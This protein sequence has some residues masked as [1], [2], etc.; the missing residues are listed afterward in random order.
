[1]AVFV[2]D[3]STFAIEASIEARGGPPFG[4]VR[5]WLANRYV[6][7]YE[8]PVPLFTFLSSIKRIPDLDIGAAGE[9]A[10]SDEAFLAGVISGAMKGGDKYRLYL[11]ES[12]DDFSVVGY[13]G[14]EV[15][16]IVWSL[17]EN[18]FFSYPD[19]P[20]GIQSASVPSQAFER[21][22]ANFE[23]AVRGG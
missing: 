19:Y 23:A 15:I 2:G 3:K 22:V 13:R 14:R 7:A 20:A 17:H 21:V 1:M 12:F 16:R 11:G 5:I 4:G 10:R 6:G 8:D 18:P 9:F